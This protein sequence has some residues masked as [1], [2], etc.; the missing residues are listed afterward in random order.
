MKRYLLYFLWSSFRRCEV[1]PIVRTS[2]A[3]FA[4]WLTTLEIG[5]E[6]Y[7]V[8]EQLT[9]TTLVVIPYSFLSLLL[10][11]EHPK[12]RTWLARIF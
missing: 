12:V 9:Y 7:L 6:T 4:P 8:V 10:L 3:F 2:I 1:Y 11:P 5:H